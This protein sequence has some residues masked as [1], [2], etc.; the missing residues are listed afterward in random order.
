VYVLVDGEP[1]CGGTRAVLG[2][3]VRAAL[4]Q[5]VQEVEVWYSPRF[6]S[7]GSCAGQSRIGWDRSRARMSG[8]RDVLFFLCGLRICFVLA[9]AFSFVSWAPLTFSIVLLLERGSFPM[10]IQE[11]NKIREGF[12][13]GPLFLC[14]F[15]RCLEVFGWCH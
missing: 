8:E 11:F 7:A 13:R 15:G 9:G 5:L 4:V 2:I 12:V 14:R 10:V 6:A 1:M 3:C